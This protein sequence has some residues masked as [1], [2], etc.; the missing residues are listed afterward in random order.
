MSGHE[1]LKINGVFMELVEV[2][3]FEAANRLSTIKGGVKVYIPQV[4]GIPDDHWL[5]HAVG[6]EAA[7]K[8]ME[9]FGG[10]CLEIPLGPV[11]GNR[12]KTR[13]I[14]RQALE[15]GVSV[16][17]IAITCGVHRRTVQRHKNNSSGTCTG[18]KRVV[19]ESLVLEVKR[20]AREIHATPL[21]L[22]AIFRTVLRRIPK[23][24]LR[25]YLLKLRNEINNTN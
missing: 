22:L 23:E 3:G 1:P 2:A 13:A 19:P 9:R 14:I 20:V 6:K 17:Q 24:Q 21:E 18:N 7:D 10:E 16:D 11:A 15:S 8:L 12:N 25:A 5:L 4:G